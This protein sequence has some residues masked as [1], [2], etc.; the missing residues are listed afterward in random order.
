MQ[1]ELLSAEILLSPVNT[2]QAT[3][4]IDIELHKIEQKLQSY[5]CSAS[6]FE[7]SVAVLSGLFAG[8]VYA[9]VVGDTPI[10]QNNQ[11]PVS[12]QIIDVFNR[13]NYAVLN[14][15][16]GL[17][18]GVR[19]S[20]KGTPNFFSQ[21]IPDVVSSFIPELERA[22]ANA[23]PIGMIAS[24]LLQIIHGGI[25]QI[26]KDKVQW[27]PNVVSQED[28]ILL[29]SIAVIVGLLKWL[30]DVSAQDREKMPSSFKMLDKLRELIHSTPAFSTIVKEMDQ[31]QRK[32]LK[33]MKSKDWKSNGD[34]SVEKVF[35]SFFTMMIGNIPFFQNTDFQ[36]AGRILQT[37]NHVGVNDIPI[38]HILM[39][40]GF[41]VLLNEMIVRTFF[42][43]IRLAEELKR[44]EK[45]ESIDWSRVLPFGNRDIDRLLTISTMTLSVADT[46]D[47]VIHAAIDSYG[48]GLLFATRFVNRF[49]YVA[50]GRAV[51]AVVKEVSNERA[52]AELVYR[53]RLLTEVK[54]AKVIEALQNYQDQLEKRVS[55]Y[56]TEDITAFLQ[57]FDLMDQGLAQKNSDLVIKGNIIIQNKLGRTSQFT[58]QHEFDELMDSDTPLKF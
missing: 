41:P 38:M 8:A 24:V 26:K 54:N 43:A 49:N 32:L 35:Y 53:R 55:E 25:L 50:F 7:Y 27:L 11:K 40:Q 13:M 21:F 1:N 18:G 30:S 16:N 19:T 46:A 2:A 29:V 51:F 48:D 57:G 14:Q 44:N 31:W 42:F 15:G 22:S 58:D 34:A 12:E 56:L 9:L 17:A 52:E 5:S 36:K 39:S 20:G 33:E 23:S 6:M 10:F 28:K 4:D 37:G 47:A 45:T 3:A